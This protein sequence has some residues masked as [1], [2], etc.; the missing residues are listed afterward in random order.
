[1]LSIIITTRDTEALLKNLLSSIKKDKMLEPLLKEVIVVD[2]ASA[3]RTGDMVKKDFPGYLY[4][5]NERNE[6]FAAAVNK[7]FFHSVGEYILF[8]NS[9]TLLIEGEIL[10]ILDLMKE[11][12]DIGICGPQLVYPDMSP[13][14]S[15]AFAPS[16]VSEIFPRALIEF[17][18]P[19]TISARPS[20][21]R[22]P[23]SALDVPSLIG[24]A[25]LIRRNVLESLGAFDDRFFFFLEET[26]LCLR[27]RK[28][29]F[30]TEGK[31]FRVVFYPHA[32]VIHLQGK[33]VAKNWVKG[34]IEYN[35]SLY[36]F[37]RKHHTCLYYMTFKAVRFTK[38]C[39]FLIIFSTLPFFPVKD[40]LKR[41]Y[42]YY[43]K[44]FLWHIKGCP[45]NGGLRG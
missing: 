36:K 30:G 37:I 19:E 26:D 4:I 21:L 28:I 16:L 20:A 32:K 22:A 41:S 3:D 6:G 5:K 38:C 7:G 14:R 1:M 17:L 44:L 39:I 18:S 24:A 40:K 15:F 12:P 8:L 27:T 35:I 34:R 29:K 23:S 2:N 9:D 42:T 45:D 25:V 10:K 13:Q 43:T 31:T 33:T 11:N